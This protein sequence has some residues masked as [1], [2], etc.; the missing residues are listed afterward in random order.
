M[1][2]NL[3]ASG[4]VHSSPEVTM[5]LVKSIGVECT[6]NNLLTVQRTKCIASVM[7]SCLLTCCLLALKKSQPY[8]FCS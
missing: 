1:N 3:R 5:F 2:P 6:L 7:R 4:Q 8:T